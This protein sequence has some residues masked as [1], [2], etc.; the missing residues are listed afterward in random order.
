MSYREIEIAETS[1]N[2]VVRDIFKLEDEHVWRISAAIKD[3]AIAVAEQEI[4][5]LFNRGDFR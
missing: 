1:L 3:L 4:D 5:R 2:A